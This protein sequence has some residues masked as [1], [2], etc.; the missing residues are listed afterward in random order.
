MHQWVASRYWR[1]QPVNLQCYIATLTVH[2]SNNDWDITYYYH[3]TLTICVYTCCAVHMV[4]CLC[5]RNP[6]RRPHQQFFRVVMHSDM[7]F[8][9]LPLRQH[10][11]YWVFCNKYANLVLMDGI[12]MYYVY[13]GGGGTWVF[14]LTPSPPL[15]W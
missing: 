10:G 13:G 9:M 5:M 8:A 6:T 15:S 14:A 12:V 1:W 3:R 11:T 4:Y 2:L 7:R